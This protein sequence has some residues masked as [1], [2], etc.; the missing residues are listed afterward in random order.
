MF[1]FVFYGV[2]GRYP[3]FY[4]RF[5]WLI[6]CPALLLALWVASLIDY[7]PPSYRQ[8]MYPV[9][10]QVLGWT[11]ASLSLLCIPVYAVVTIVRA[12]GKNLGEVTITFIFIFN[13][14]T[15]YRRYAT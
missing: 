4:F 13:P 1:N 10:A 15:R 11:I 2:V 8:Y 9:W 14:S 6:A 12:P 3:S 5:C 7:N